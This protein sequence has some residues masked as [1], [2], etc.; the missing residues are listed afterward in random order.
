MSTFQKAVFNGHGENI[1]DKEK[2]VQRAVFGGEGITV[3]EEQRRRAAVKQSGQVGSAP[4]QKPVANPIVPDRPTKAKIKDAIREKC[5]K[6]KVEVP[7]E[8]WLNSS[9]T[10]WD[11]LNDF[12]NDEEYFKGD[13]NEGTPEQNKGDAELS[14]MT[15]EE[16]IRKNTEAEK[17]D[18]GEPKKGA[19]RG[20]LPPEDPEDD[21]PPDETQEQK[22][23]RLISEVVKLEG[24]PNE[25]RQGELNSMDVLSLEETMRDLRGENS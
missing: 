8:K 22:K 15:E 5:A 2:H 14:N 6:N 1:Y 17:S 7:I 23:G 25:V 19:F 4:A 20:E 11:N 21:T 24:A 13:D 18:K 3:Q 10:S 16:A 9:K 12:L